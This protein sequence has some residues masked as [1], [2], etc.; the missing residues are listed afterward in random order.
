MAVL[1]LLT[2]F[3]I[4]ILTYSISTQSPLIARSR[5][6]LTVFHQKNLTGHNYE[7]KILFWTPM[8]ELSSEELAINHRKCLLQC[9]VRCAVTSDRREVSSVD[10]VMFHLRDLWVGGIGTN[11]FVP[12]PGYRSASQVWVLYNMESLAYLQG[13]LNALNGYFNWTVWYRKDSTISIPYGQV[14]DLNKT[15]IIAMSKHL[16]T[17]NF[18]REKSKTVTGMISHCKDYARRYKVINE[19]KKYIKVE[20]FGDCYGTPCKGNFTECENLLKDY[21]FYLALENSI[22]KDYVTEKYWGA[23]ARNQVPIVNWKNISDNIVIPN[24]YINIH[25]FKDMKALAN[26]LNIV[27]YVVLPTFPTGDIREPDI[28]VR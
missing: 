26:Y 6:F 10:A 2:T 17:S 1:V 13:D 5:N 25:D 11:I 28:R 9:D 19:L 14:S 16:E 8:F 4:F 24:S 20:M 27:G 7:K 12:L 3:V 22:C 15:E 23:L 21:K 18:F